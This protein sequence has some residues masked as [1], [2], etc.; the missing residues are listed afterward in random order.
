MVELE[1]KREEGVLAEGGRSWLCVHGDVKL[2]T[3]I[4]LA[5]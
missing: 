3:L 5:C 2:R 4:S 1:R